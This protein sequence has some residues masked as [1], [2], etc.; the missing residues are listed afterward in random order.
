V[1]E[2]LIFILLEID[3]LPI[4]EQISVQKLHTYAVNV[5]EIVEI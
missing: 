5:E 3:E 1:D 2:A 4:K